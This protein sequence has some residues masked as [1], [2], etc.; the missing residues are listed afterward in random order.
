MAN[1]QQTPTKD[2]SQA[3]TAE[4]NKSPLGQNNS[5][6]NPSSQN[7]AGQNTTGQNSS[8]N[9]AKGDMNSTAKVGNNAQKDEPTAKSGDAMKDSDNMSGNA[10]KAV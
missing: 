2:Q 3:N 7:N 4:Q 5:A 10:R 8:L 9:N 1:M 6:Q